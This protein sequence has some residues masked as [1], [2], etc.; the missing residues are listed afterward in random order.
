[1]E[2]PA[3]LRPIVERITAQVDPEPAVQAVDV[4][5]LAA[6]LLKLASS[7]PTDPFL[8]AALQM[9][10]E[11]LKL[12]SF[13]WVRPN[14][15][16][17]VTYRTVMEAARLLL[18]FRALGW[19]A[20]RAA[21]ELLRSATRFCSESRSYHLQPFWAELA[22]GQVSEGLRRHLLGEGARGP[23]EHGPFALDA[24]PYELFEPE[25]RLDRPVLPVVE[26]ELPPEL[27]ELTVHL[28]LLEP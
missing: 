12:E 9:Q 13:D 25:R 14:P 5:R 26:A 18:C 8:Q 20:E 16:V 11:A 23:F 21:A 6:E 2:L 1:M 4:R 19:R 22:S 27:D 17:T 10:L 28:A 24:F 3:S 7:E 15:K